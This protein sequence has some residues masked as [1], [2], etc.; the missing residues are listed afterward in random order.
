[1]KN[2]YGKPVQTTQVSCRSGK[3]AVTFDGTFCLLSGR[4]KTAVME[5]TM[6]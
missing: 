3:T 6:T 1:M 4:K 5:K 2:R